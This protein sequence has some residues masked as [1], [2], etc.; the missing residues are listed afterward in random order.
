MGTKEKQRW[1]REAERF[2][3]LQQWAAVGH[4]AAEEQWPSL[5]YLETPL[6]ILRSLS[7]PTNTFFCTL[8][9]FQMLDCREG[10][11]IIF[12]LII[13]SAEHPCPIIPI[14]AELYFS[15][16]TRNY[17]IIGSAGIYLRVGKKG[18]K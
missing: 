4:C 2:P 13:C 5:N 16:L 3:L 9:W 12:A 6:E 10:G 18:K 11:D 17:T 8:I 14:N 15:V 1:R 7:P